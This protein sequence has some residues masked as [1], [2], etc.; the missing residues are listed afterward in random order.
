MLINWLEIDEKT[1]QSCGSFIKSFNIEQRKSINVT[2]VCGKK[3]RLNILS[4]VDFSKICNV[5]KYFPYLKQNIGKENIN[6]PLSS[7]PRAIEWRNEHLIK[8]EPYVD[9]VYTSL[10]VDFTINASVKRN[11]KNILSYVNISKICNVIKYFPGLKQNIG[12]EDI[13]CPL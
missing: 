13:Y 5:I 10:Y 6:S 4:H 9:Q 1:Y 12:K 3:K 2:N 7:I 11:G 8:L